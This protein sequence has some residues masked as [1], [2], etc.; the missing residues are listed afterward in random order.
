MNVAMPRTTPLDADA[1]A[2]VCIVGAG[3]AG[4]TSAYL[5]LREGKKVIV[6][7]RGEIGGG[8]TGRTTSHLASDLDDGVAKIEHLHGADIARLAVASHAA[9]IDRIE[10]IATDEHI[11]CQLR[12]VDAYLFNPP[13]EDADKLER[14]YEAVRKTGWLE[15][16][17]V[18][19]APFSAFETGRCLRYTNQAMIHPLQYL[20]GIARAVVELG[21]RIHTQTPVGEKYEAGPPVIVATDSAHTVV[22]ESLIVATNAP[23]INFFEV[24]TKQTAMRSYVIAATIR[25]GSVPYALFW[26][27]ADPYH[28]A[29]VQPDP[30]HHRELLIVGGED[31]KVGRDDTPEDR[32]AALEVWAR[33]RF[34]EML[35][36]EY[37]WSGQ[38][39]EPMDGLAFIGR[40]PKHPDIY[41]IT[42]DSGQGMTHGTLGAMLVS[43][44]I[45]GRANPWEAMYAPARKR[46]RT[47]GSFIAE[48]ASNTAQYAAYVTGGDVE[49]PEQ[50]SAGSGAVLRRGTHKVAVYRDPLGNLHERSAVCTH[51]GCV[52]RWNSVEHTWDCPCHGSR[53]LPLGEVVNGPAVAP[54]HHIDTGVANDQRVEQA[55]ADSFPASDAPSHTPVTG[56]STLPHRKR[57]TRNTR[58][59]DVY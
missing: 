8:E 31:H 24:Q 49:S 7:E 16:S 40:Y 30:S 42:G 5:L 54:L 26:D 22:A 51:L 14:E 17:W 2:D 33:E 48:H 9:A 23:A 15:A 35:D 18:P 28:Y 37:H 56:A 19:G 50:I 53:F 12:R 39:L 29:R 3:I 10:Q 57:R 47:A 52:V 32:F 11:D 41:C 20:Q 34:P 4:L 36:V 13:G 25:R 55:S 43:D 44:L 59:E 58:R 27:T 6:L 21:G 46:L 38:I 1:R 45:L